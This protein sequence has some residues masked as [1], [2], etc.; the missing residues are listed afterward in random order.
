MPKNKPEYYIQKITESNPGRYDLSNCVFTTSRSHVEVFCIKGQHIFTQRP[1]KLI[2]GI[3]CSQCYGYVGIKHDNSIFIEKTVKKYGDG[4]YGFDRLQYKNAHTDVE[5]F[6]TT[7]NG[8][9]KIKPNHFLQD[10]SGC[11]ICQRNTMYST[12]EF[13]EKCKQ[14]HGTKYSYEQTVYTGQKDDVIIFCNDHNDYYKISP[15][16]LLKGKTGCAICTGKVHTHDTFVAKAI[17][18]HGDKYDYS[19]ESFVHSENKMNILCREHGLFAQAPRAH[20]SGRGC[21]SCGEYGYQPGKSGV[22]YIQKLVNSNKTVYKFGISGNVKR[23]M[24]EQKRNSQFEH[25]LVFEKSFDDGKDALLL[26]NAIKSTVPYGI[27]TKEELKSGF[28]ETFLE[29]HLETVMNIINSF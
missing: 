13:I 25:E 11:N 28:T 16:T 5:L 29:E 15:K 17:L 12:E 3:G 27:L 23:R 10:G 6:C 19:T 24:T 2:K 22:F 7:H 18:V 21:P 8:Y 26:E 4:L 20:L 9:F 1:D 14:I